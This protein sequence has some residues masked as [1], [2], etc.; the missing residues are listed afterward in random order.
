MDR[1]LKSATWPEFV[2]LLLDRFGRDQHELLIRQLFQIRQ[3]GLVTDYIERFSELVDQLDA[4]ESKTDPLYY[5]MHFIDG[6][7]DDVKAMVLVQRPTDLDTA[8]ILAQLQE[9]VADSGRSKDFCKQEYSSSSKPTFKGSHPLPPK[10][11]KPPVTS[12]EDRRGTEAAC[13]RSPSE[14]LAALRAYR[15][16]QGFVYEVCCEM[17]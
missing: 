8:C 9:E 11:D 17:A 5:T 12:A 1:R 4:Y 6:L 15:R 14:K 13:H 2:K 10:V 7:R 16:A 3:S